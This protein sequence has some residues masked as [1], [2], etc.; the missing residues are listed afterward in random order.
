MAKVHIFNPD[1]DYALAANRDY[2]T[3]PASIVAIRSA[4]A[5]L[6]ALYAEK[7]DM[8]LLLDNPA[9]RIENLEFYSLCLSKNITIF[10]PDNL[11]A[12]KKN[13]IN[14]MFE[15]W[16]WNRSIRQLL[17][18]I[19]G[20]LPNIPSFEKIMAIRE[21]SHRRTTIKFLECF[22]DVLD[23]EIEIPVE[24]YSPESA[25]EM[26][27]KNR[28]MYFKAPWSSSGRGIMLTDDLEEKHVFPWVK[29]KIRSQG[30]VIA[31]KAYDRS[32][33][34]ASE[35]ICCKG[36]V[37]FLGLSIFN[38]SRRGKYL[39]NL[40]I[41]QGEI[42]DL[43]RKHAP[44]FSDKILQLQQSALKTLIAPN[45]DGPVGIDMLA[46]TGGAI[47]PCV[48]INLRHTMGMINLLKP[49]TIKHC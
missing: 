36:E 10:S 26:Y 46:T 29:G 2:Y 27:R 42:K 3:P 16:G 49:N 9:T 13:P 33:D 24:V 38:V 35:W 41:S 39:S 7:E 6:P 44:R 25:L 17:I 22:G 48:E 32:L 23:A 30:S 34:F 4:K 21:L 45:Y 40:D 1:T 11:A 12:L 18:D 19:F 20:D 5:L 8:I 28:A 14:L 37:T 31:E 15:P 47:N 43:L